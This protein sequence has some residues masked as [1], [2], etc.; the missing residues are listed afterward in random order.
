MK[1]EEEEEEKGRKLQEGEAKCVHPCCWGSRASLH[2]VCVC[3]CVSR[4]Q[5][6]KVGQNRFNWCFS[7]QI[8]QKCTWGRMTEELEGLRKCFWGF[9]VFINELVCSVTCASV[10]QVFT[11]W[12]PW[13]WT[14]KCCRAVQKTAERTTGNELMHKKIFFYGS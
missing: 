9:S 3:V 1:W 6:I 7:A 14:V 11:K 10:C 5:Q 12:Q 2:C 4:A 8:Q 13:S